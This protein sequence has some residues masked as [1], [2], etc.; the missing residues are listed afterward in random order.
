MCA[1]REPDDRCFLTFFITIWRT[2]GIDEEL[3]PVLIQSFTSWL[4][5]ATMCRGYL[6][7][8]VMLEMICMAHQQRLRCR[9]RLLEASET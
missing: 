7:Y 1:R 8:R 5:V 4:T 3:V 2:R 9:Q 6:K